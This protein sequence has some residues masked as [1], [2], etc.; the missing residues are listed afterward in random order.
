MGYP[1]IFETKI[2]NLPDGRLLHLSLSGCNNDNEGRDRHEFHG[3]I[4]SKE[5]WNAYIKSFLN[6]NEDTYEG[7]DLKI[8]NRYC[9]WKDYAKHLSTMQKRAMTWEELKELHSCY[10]LTYDGIIVYLKDG[11]EKFYAAGSEATEAFNLMQN[12]AILYTSYRRVRR[13]LHDINSIVKEL[14]EQ[15]HMEFF[16][17]R[18][19][20]ELKMNS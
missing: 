5:E 8:G 7:F 13:D 16:V 3:K 4:Y 17:S 14:E 15:T 1:I 11:S 18:R 2:V 19:K 12:K 20:K 9:R 6:D 10:A